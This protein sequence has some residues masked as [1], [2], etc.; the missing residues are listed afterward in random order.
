MDSDD[1]AHFLVLITRSCSLFFLDWSLSFLRL[2]LSFGLCWS[3]ITQLLRDNSCTWVISPVFFVFVGK[4]QNNLPRA[5]YPCAFPGEVFSVY[6]ATYL[7]LTCCTVLSGSWLQSSPAA[8]LHHLPVNRLP[9]QIHLLLCLLSVP[10][11]HMPRLTWL[12]ACHLLH[13]NHLQEHL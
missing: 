3:I 10:S 1:L 6:W 5:I 4:F 2:T 13:I 11:T 9:P 7:R 12:V 8:Q